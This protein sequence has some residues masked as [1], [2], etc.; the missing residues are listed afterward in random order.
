M[1]MHTDDLVAFPVRIKL[2]GMNSVSVT[3]SGTVHQASVIVDRECAVH[4][5]IFSIT[6]GIKHA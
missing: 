1:L 2:T 6:I 4:N 3:E 5:L